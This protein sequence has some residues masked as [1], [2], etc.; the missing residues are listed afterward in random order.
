VP[1]RTGRPAAKNPRRTPRGTA[2]ALAAAT[3]AAFLAACTA[4]SAAVRE[5]A[6]ADCPLLIAHRGYTGSAHGT[7]PVPANS[8]AAIGDAAGHGAT[9][10]E[11]DARWSADDVPVVI[12]NATV[13]ATTRRRGKV[14][15]YQSVTLKKMRLRSFSGVTSA[16]LPS[17]A[18]MLRQVVRDHLKAVIQ[19][20]TNRVTAAQA[21]SFTAAID[22]AG[23]Q[24]AV[25]IHSFYPASLAALPAYPRTLLTETPVTAAPGDVGVDLRG[26]IVTAALVARLHA[27]GLTVG[28]WTSPGSGVRDNKGT[29]AR[30]AADGV[31]RI[32]T[33]GTAAYVSWCGRV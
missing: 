29:W 17:L 33:N 7:G 13:N 28:A 25:S 2:R 9:V 18:R 15:S 27:A 20:K 1:A 4:H 31:D 22:S 5:L 30:L 12:H 26:S 23:A 11:F 16:Y 10:V 3:A 32:I 19:I 6:T 24:R 14:A 8:A 21:A